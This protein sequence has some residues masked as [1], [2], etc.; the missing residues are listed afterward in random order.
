MV[1]DK[2]KKRMRLNQKVKESRN[3]SKKSNT[4]EKLMIFSAFAGASYTCSPKALY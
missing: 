1:V 3:I 4:N 2:I